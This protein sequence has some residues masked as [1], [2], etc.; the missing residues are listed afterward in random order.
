MERI[1]VVHYVGDECTYC[2]ENIVALEAESAEEFYV[3]FEQAMRSFLDVAE[4]NGEYPRGTYQV[5][6]HKFDVM[7]FRY[8]VEKPSWDKSKGRKWELEMPEVYT[9]DEWFEKNKV[10]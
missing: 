1:V 4:A 5:G 9:L 10:T 6:K 7:D 2:Y 3:R 8:A